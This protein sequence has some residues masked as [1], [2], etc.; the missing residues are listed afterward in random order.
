MSTT[1]RRRTL[2]AILG[3]AAAAHGQTESVEVFV[4]DPRPLNEAIYQFVRRHPITVTYEDPR[5]EFAGD[6]RDVTDQ[7]RRGPL[8][9]EVLTQECHALGGGLAKHG[10]RS[11]VAGMSPRQREQVLLE[12]P[13][14]VDAP[15]RLFVRDHLLD[16]RDLFQRMQ[17]L[18]GTNDLPHS[19]DDG[20][21]EIVIA[22]VL[23]N[24]CQVGQ[25]TD[26]ALGVRAVSRFFLLNPLGNLL[27]PLGVGPEPRL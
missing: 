22:A 26:Q 3:F 2:L 13:R 20:D 5:F 11:D 19:V 16:Q 21:C 9:G 17:A 14:R 10:D 7:V 4:D 6:L 27:L 25:G 23:I 1:R 12:L 18:V 24:E 15:D 8:T